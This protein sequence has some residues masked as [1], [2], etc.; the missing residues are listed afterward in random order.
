MVEGTVTHNT[1]TLEQQHQQ[2][3]V[4]GAVTHNTII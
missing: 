4:E 1:I 2:H 3:M